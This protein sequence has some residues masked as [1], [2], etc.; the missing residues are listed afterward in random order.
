MS[1]ATPWMLA[2]LLAMAVPVIVHLINRRHATRRPFP[3]MRLLLE[4]QERIARGLKVKQALLLA[5]RVLLFA[6]LPLAM[7]RPF[8]DCAGQEALTADERMPASVV[9]VIDDSASMSFTD[10]RA[11]RW[12]EAVAEARNQLRRLRPW[13]RVQIV[14]AGGTARLHLPETGGTR[15]EAEAVLADL[16]PRFGDADLPAALARAREAHRGLLQPVQRTVVLTDDLA[17]SWSGPGT[18]PEAL[19]G[20]GGVEVVRTGGA[21]ATAHVHI[22]RLDLEEATDVGPGSWRIRAVLRAEGQPPSDVQAALWTGGARQAQVRVALAAEGRGVAEFIVQHAGAEALPVRVAVTDGP[23]MVALAE[24][25]GVIRPRRAIQVLLVNGD[26]RAQA[27]NDELFYLNAA[28]AAVDPESRPVSARETVPS[29]LGEALQ[30]GAD[31]VV[32]ANVDRLAPADATRLQRF[33][34]DGGGVWFTVGDQVDPEVW[35]ERFGELLPRRLRAVR[36][37]AERRDPDA[38][39]K[40]TRLAGFDA[41]HPVLRVF[42]GRSAEALRGATVFTYMLVEPGGEESDT[43]LEFGDGA[44]ALVAGRLGRG[45]T[46][47]WT[48]TIDFDWTDL[49]IRPAY[50]PFV[51]RSLVWLGGGAG[52]ALEE[53][54]V[55]G[56]WVLEPDHGAATLVEVVDP[57]G[58]LWRHPVEGDRVRHGV[59]QRGVHEARILDARGDAIG[60]SWMVA[61]APRAQVDPTPADDAIRDPWLSA[62]GEGG[63]IRPAAGDGGPRGQ[64]MW[65][66]LLFLAVVLLYAESLVSLRRRLWRRIRSWRQP[67][68]DAR[69]G[70]LPLTPSAR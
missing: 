46:L 65:G 64:G 10:G 11:D 58:E 3:A 41:G 47:L 53:V 24:R 63:G 48:S 2:G 8:I 9:L 16:E 37:L 1:F 38:R 56:T 23:R 29:Q 39:I 32:L 36:T 18:R 61:H 14:T 40:A 21:A 50:V 17:R 15:A 62:A 20:L 67:G 34:E 51:H 59:A 44:P 55:G 30:A 45:R 42:S 27:H 12:E 49:P 22:E 54:E 28:L 66:V 35:N 19:S 26:P 25:H 7:A 69:R 52:G 5:L 70:E 68:S 43:L 13:D 6:A 60:R 57:S 31:V 4:S 33:V